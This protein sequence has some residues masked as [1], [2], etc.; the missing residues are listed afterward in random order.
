MTYALYA[1]TNTGRP[2]GQAYVGGERDARGSAALPTATWSHLAVT[3]DGTT[4]RLFVNGVQTG[5]AAG[6]GAMAVSSR[7]LKLGGNA[8]FSD[9][10]YAGLLDDVRIYNRTLSA[11]EIQGDMTRPA[12]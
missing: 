5:S 1:G 11:S 2:T 4:V 7:P 8:V 6:G 3:Y 12:P 10:W 9:E